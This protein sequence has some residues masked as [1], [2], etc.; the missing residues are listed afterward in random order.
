LVALTDVLVPEGRRTLAYQEDTVVRPDH[1]NRGLGRWVKAEM[2]RW[3]AEEEPQLEQIVTWN[4]TENA[5]MRDINTELGFVA[6]D[7]WAEWQFNVD[8]LLDR[9]G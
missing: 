1:R 2:L 9:V 7:T 3:L 6:G 4:A 8:A 5:A